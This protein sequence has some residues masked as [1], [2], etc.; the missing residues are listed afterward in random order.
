LEEP[1]LA[2][3]VNIRNQL[4]SGGNPVQLVNWRVSTDQKAF[5]IGVKLDDSY[6]TPEDAFHCQ[7]LAR[8]KDPPE[9]RQLE[10]VLQHQPKTI[11]YCES[12]SRLKGRDRNKNVVIDEA[13]FQLPFKV[14]H[15]LTTKS[16]DCLFHGI[17]TETKQNGVHFLQ[18]EL[19]GEMVDDYSPM[20]GSL[21]SSSV[22]PS[23]LLLLLLAALSL[24]KMKTKMKAM[25][26]TLMCL[27]TIPNWNVTL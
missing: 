20:K 23:G 6:M 8:V 16:K 4:L 2:K 9:R 1:T 26:T 10:M 14:Q 7:T 13:R 17:K 27:L 19:I 5:I 21:S 18:V 25:K 11:A 24:Q 22:A 15:R 3:R 12:V